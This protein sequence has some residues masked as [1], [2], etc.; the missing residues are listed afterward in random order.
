MYQHKL[1]VYFKRT[2]LVEVFVFVFIFIFRYVSQVFVCDS[3][4]SKCQ[5]IS[6]SIIM[7]LKIF[8]T[9]KNIILKLAIKP[10]S[11]LHFCFLVYSNKLHVSSY[12]YTPYKSFY[13]FSTASNIFC[14]W[15]SKQTV[16]H[17]VCIWFIHRYSLV[18]SASN[19]PPNVQYNK[20][21]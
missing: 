14:L 21:S 5:R 12:T 6:L 13:R 8:D 7:Q 16:F 20:T 11:I 19:W 9:N 18:M 1:N 2:V 4:M 15:H 17:C 3:E 10:I